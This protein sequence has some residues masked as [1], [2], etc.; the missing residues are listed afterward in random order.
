MIFLFKF[1][2]IMGRDIRFSKSFN[3]RTD[4]LFLQ[5]FTLFSQPL[6][7]GESIHSQRQKNKR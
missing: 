2:K 1:I 3:E 4:E 6:L 5:S 7:F